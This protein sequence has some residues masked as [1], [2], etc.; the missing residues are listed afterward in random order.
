MCIHIYIHTYTCVYIYIYTYIYIY[1]YIYIYT[2][3]YIYI[4]THTSPP[5][6]SSRFWKVPARSLPAPH[7]K[8]RE[9]SHTCKLNILADLTCIKAFKMIYLEGAG[10]SRKASRAWCSRDSSKGVQ[11]KQGVAIYMMLYTSLLCDTTPIHCTPLPPHPPVMNTHV[12][13]RLVLVGICQ[14]PPPLGAPSL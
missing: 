10:T 14:C 11:W 7:G 6:R 1:I 5:R 2:Y 4:H 12:G 13:S 9:P 3:I 8:L